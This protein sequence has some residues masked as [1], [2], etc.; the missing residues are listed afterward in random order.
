MSKKERDVSAYITPLG[1]FLYA[2]N[3]EQIDLQDLALISERNNVSRIQKCRINV[4]SG[5]ERWVRKEERFTGQGK[6]P[7]ISKFIFT[8]KTGNSKLCQVDYICVKR[9][10]KACVCICVHVFLRAVAGRLEKVQSR[11]VFAGL[12]TE[13]RD[14]SYQEHLQFLKSEVWKLSI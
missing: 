6:C 7:N 5:W 9:K 11:W 3:P 13:R 10:T 14:H 2:V 4:N 12:G 1:A 8:W